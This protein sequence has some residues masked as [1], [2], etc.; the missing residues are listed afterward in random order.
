MGY[1]GKGAAVTVAVVQI[2]HSTNSGS[3]DGGIGRDR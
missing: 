2:E 1:G 3:W